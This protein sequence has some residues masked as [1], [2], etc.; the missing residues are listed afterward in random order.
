MFA[1]TLKQWRQAISRTF[2]GAAPKPQHKPTGRSPVTF[3]LYSGIIPVDEVQALTK[4]EARAKFKAAR[5]I[6]GRLPK[7]LTVTQKRRLA[8]SA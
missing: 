1:M 6:K 3:V 8:K 5:G 4:S 7:S 2:T